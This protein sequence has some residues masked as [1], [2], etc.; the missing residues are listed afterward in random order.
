MLEGGFFLYNACLSV[1]PF[2]SNKRQNGVTDRAQ[3]LCGTLHDPRE[4]FLEKQNWKKKI[5]KNTWIYFKCAN[6]KRK[7]RQNL[8]MILNGRLLEQQLKAKLI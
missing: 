7:I 1:Y 6:S 2:V 5:Q 8:K 3:I 4:R